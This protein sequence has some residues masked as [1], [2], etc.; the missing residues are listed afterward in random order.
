MLRE[1]A[2]KCLTDD[3]ASEDCDP[4]MGTVPLDGCTRKRANRA[5]PVT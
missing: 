2:G 3:A 1:A 4:H 5:T